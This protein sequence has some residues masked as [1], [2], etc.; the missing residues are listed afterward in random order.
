M[1]RGW[2][3]I[4]VGLAFWILTLHATPQMPYN[5][6][7]F[8]AAVL[9]ATSQTSTPIILHP[10]ISPG[11]GSFSAGSVTVTGVA[12]TT[13]TF[14][15]LVQKT[16]G[17]PYLATA[18]EA[19]GVPGTFTTTVTATASGCYEFNLQGAI[20]VEFQT[21]GTFTATSIS[22]AMTAS[23]NGQISRGGA[24]GS[25]GATGATGA[26][27]PTGATGA[28]GTNGTAG[29]T[30]ST[31]PAGSTGATGATGTN[32]TNGTNGSTG[33]T[34]A[35]G[36]TGSTG[37]TGATGTTTGTAGGDL[38]GTYPNPTVTQI[39]GGVIPLSA[40]VIGTNGSGQPTAPTTTG[41]GN[42]VLQTSP[43]FLTS[44]VVPLMLAGNSGNTTATLT[45][46]LGG[47]NGT[48]NING[49]SSANTGTGTINLIGENS[50][51]STANGTVALTGGLGTGTNALTFAGAGTASAHNGSVSIFGGD[52]SANGSSSTNLVNV[53]PNNAQSHSFFSFYNLQPYS[54]GQTG[55][56][57]TRLV[58]QATTDSNGYVNPIFGELVAY[59]TGNSTST[60][61]MEHAFEGCVNS[62]GVWIIVSPCP[63]TVVHD[64]VFHYSL[65]GG[66]NY[67]I[68][69][70]VFN[71]TTDTSA[72]S[73]HQ[74][75]IPVKFENPIQFFQTTAPVA[76]SCGGGTVAAGGTDNVFKVTGITAATAC[77]I[78]FNIGVHQGVCVGNTST[79]IATGPTTATTS[80][81]TFGMAALTGTLYAV[82]Y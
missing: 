58:T 55:A 64:Y 17:G 38:G 29:A 19:C 82:C 39:E 23:P 18:I 50:A 41:T 46:S 42:V 30:G 71:P 75:Y 61:L 72:N 16:P 1:K 11:T 37:A 66:T 24:S 7:A 69:D 76:S 79:G 3:W 74:F 54:A 8:P 6:V 5:N 25:G 59:N 14:A 51:A 65:T 33:A 20:A 32:G 9:T 2:R 28:T 34:G 73:I 70:T 31:G 26:T 45:G 63:L 52:G 21:S 78:T 15:V 22:L 36:A 12:L 81:V 10:G 47:A 57:S 4:A 67:T 27:G 60:S 80:L 53:I 62:S 44:M 40:V 48:V 68:E 13:A 35:T 56:G 43:T 49:G 77:T